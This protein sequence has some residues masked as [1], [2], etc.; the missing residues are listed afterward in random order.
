MRFA[1]FILVGLNIWNSL[2]I[3]PFAVFIAYFT[4]WTLLITF[5]CILIGIFLAEFEFLTHEKWPRLHASHHVLYSLMLFMNPIV[6]C[7]YW[8]FVHDEH[9]EEL[10]VKYSHDPQLLEWKT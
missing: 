1:L 3:T 8:I 9:L 10:Q 7:V 2:S 5:A 6:V 4:N